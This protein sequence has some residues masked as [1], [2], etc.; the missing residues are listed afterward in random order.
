MARMKL[1]R[2][3]EVET[4]EN[5]LQWTKKDTKKKIEQEI[6]KY[7]KR[8]L[9][10]ACGKGEYTI[11][12]A[13]INPNN[14]YIGVDIQGERLWR[15]S[16]IATEEKLSNVYFLR[17]PIDVLDNYI[18]KKSIDE[19]WITFP[20]P[21]LKERFARKRLT[22]EKF[23]KIYKKIL[24]RNAVINLKTDSK[25]LFEFTLKTVSECKGEIIKNIWDIYSKK[26]IKEE[27]EI[28]TTF[29]NKHLKNNKKIGYIQFRV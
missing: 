23:L 29:E 24:K 11:A 13:K 22:S 27:L 26:N 1:K 16:K 19:I 3:A 15:G 28:K 14:I 7:D 12:L 9:E 18:P 17:S 5:V 4:F 2:F 25:E 20:D 8:I 6:K 10:L 21:F